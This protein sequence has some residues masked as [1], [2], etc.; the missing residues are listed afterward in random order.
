MRTGIKSFVSVLCLTSLLLTGCA[1]SYK[2][3]PNDYKSKKIAAD[4]SYRN[5]NTVFNRVNSTMSTPTGGSLVGALIAITVQAAIVANAQVNAQKFANSVQTALRDYDFEGNVKSPTRR[6]IQNSGWIDVRSFKDM[7]HY[8]TADGVMLDSKYEH[9][10][11]VGYSYELVSNNLLRN[12]L[13]FQIYKKGDTSQ[14]IYQAKLI[15][16]YIIPGSGLF[17]GDQEGDWQSDNGKIIKRAVTETTQKLNQ[18]LAYLLKDPTNK[19]RYNE[20]ATATKNTSKTAKQ[21]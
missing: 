8:G 14:P 3:L 7:S 11:F 2:S 17:D 13:Y 9:G 19:N 18:K 5:N 12:T 20:I 6:T 4:V 10:V 15:E 16:D 1:S 21:N